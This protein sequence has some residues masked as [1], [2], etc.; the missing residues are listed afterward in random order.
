MEIAPR[1]AARSGV[2]AEAVVRERATTPNPESSVSKNL[3]IV[4]S[5]PRTGKS[6]VALGLMQL[7]SRDLQSVAFFRPI[8]SVSEDRKDKDIELILI[9]FDLPQSYDEAFAVTLKKA[10][11]MINKGEH[12]ELINIILAKYKALEA[13]YDFVLVECTDFLGG[14]AAFEFDIN[15]EIARNLNCPVL[16]VV[17]GQGKSDEEVIQAGKLALDQIDAEGLEILGVIVNRAETHNPRHITTSLKESVTYKGDFLAYVIPDDPRLANPTMSDV[18]KWLGAEVLYGREQLGN[19][20]GDYLVAAMQVGNYLE[21][22]KKDCLV[23]TPGDR[24]DIILA[25]FAARVSA[26]FADPAGVVVTGGIPPANSVKRLIQGWTGV[27]MPVLAVKDHTFK[28]AQTLMELHGR[29]DPEDKRKIASALGLFEQNVESEA[30]RGK[31][32][33]ACSTKMTPKMFEYNLI[34]QAKHDKRRIVLPEGKSERI[35]KAA[36]IILRRNIAELV[37]LGDVGEIG[38]TASHLGLNLER[39]KLV[40]P[41]KSPDFEQYSQAYFEYRKHKG[42]TPELARDIMAD[43]TYFGS[44][45]VHKGHADGMVSGSI[46]TTQHTIRPAFEFIKTKPGFSIVSSVFFMC[47]KDRVLVFGDCAVNPNP[48]AKELAEIAVASA[49][50]AR[51][52]GVDPRV[53]LLSYSTGD[54]GKGED[55]ERVR[56]AA[57]L[58]KG[59]EPDLPLEGPIQYDAAID[60][61]TAKTKLPNSQVAGRATVFIFPDLNTGNNTYKAVQRA[62]NAVAVGPVLQGLNKPVNDLSRGCTVDDIVNTVAITAIQAQSVGPRRNP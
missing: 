15:A 38:R 50:T 4:A 13:Q 6:A 43:P 33:A 61:E 32:V 59:M 51:A 57:M 49:H 12:D 53:A 1:V 39:A 5:E 3:Y 2:G 14:D 23:V 27:P 37:I 30:L 31:V 10:R 45:M 36:D 8:I 21:Y 54:S 22:V 28:V 35:L 29:I 58:A 55:V 44:M 62:S 24:S 34:E 26:E 40:D 18:Q 47:L 60:P 7:I 52:F 16:M 48:N 46:S 56:E 41:V 25:T 42:V 9:H 20:V 11:E 19:S 17:N